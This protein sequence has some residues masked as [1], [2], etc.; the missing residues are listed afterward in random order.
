MLEEEE[1]KLTGANRLFEYGSDES[2]NSYGH[3]PFTLPPAFQPMPNFGQY[4]SNEFLFHSPHLNQRRHSSYSHEDILHMKYQNPPVDPRYRDSRTF[5]KSS[6]NIYDHARRDFMSRR[7]SSSSLQDDILRPFQQMQLNEYLRKSS[8]TINRTRSNSPNASSDKSNSNWNLNPAIF[9][10]EYNDNQSEVKSNNSSTNLSYT[11]ESPNQPLNEESVAGCDDIP[12]IDDIDNGDQAAFDAHHSK[13]HNCEL[14]NDSRNASR[15]PYTVAAVQRP[16]DAAV[17]FMNKNRKTV[18][19]DLMDSMEELNKIRRSNVILNK[20]NTCDHITNV[21]LNKRKMAAAVGTS[22][23]VANATNEPI[24]KL[25]TLKE[26][27]PTVAHPTNDRTESFKKNPSVDNNNSDCSCKNLSAYFDDS[28][29]EYRTDRRDGH[30]P[31]APSIIDAKAMTLDLSDLQSDS[32]N[33]SN[34]PRPIALD[35][36]PSK[37][38]YIAAW[39]PPAFFD[40]M[41]FGHGKVQALKNYFEKMKFPADTVPI[42][43]STPDLRTAADAGEIGQ[44]LSAAERQKVLEQLQEW[45][46]FG[47]TAAEPK[48]AKPGVVTSKPIMRSVLNLTVTTSFNDR[49]SPAKADNIKWSEANRC[50]SA[51][52]IRKHKKFPEAYIVRRQKLST[53]IKSSTHETRKSCPELTGD[54]CPRAPKPFIISSKLKTNIYSSPCHR[55]SYQTLR[56]IKQNQKANKMTKCCRHRANTD[57][58]HHHQQSSAGDGDGT[59]IEPRWQ[60]RVQFMDFFKSVFVISLVFISHFR[61]LAVSVSVAVRHL[62]FE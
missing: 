55:P 6:S 34:D 58:N 29:N 48:R 12:F 19:F 41:N 13:R 53:H 54:T 61:L 50:Q 28:V 37:F 38:A 45:S 5:V 51:P 46:E 40:K 22:A 56:K 2:I 33:S 26:C 10:E 47:T 11:N 35:A 32:T 3:E 21:E 7:R 17:A 49:Q 18:S 27:T 31:S 9:I 15:D 4:N 43:Q 52:D 42:S 59:D 16:I 30:R 39:K 60:S 36:K 8:P 62:S 57:A 1:Y 25:C 23:S 14:A 24:F 20:S 44:K